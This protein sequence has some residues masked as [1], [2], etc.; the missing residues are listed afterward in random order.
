[1][2]DALRVVSRILLDSDLNFRGFEAAVNS[3]S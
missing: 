1:M 3:E 2:N